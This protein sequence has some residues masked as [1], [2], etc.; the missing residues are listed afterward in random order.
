MSIKKYTNID[1]INNK[2]GDLL[3]T[4]TQK[5]LNLFGKRIKMNGCPV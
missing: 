2:T 3:F 4:T 1:G 5:R